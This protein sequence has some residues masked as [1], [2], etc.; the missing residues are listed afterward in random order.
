MI[1]EQ[2]LS[3]FKESIV[4][5]YSEGVT[6]ETNE[7]VKFVNYISIFNKGAS[8][9]KAYR[10]IKSYDMSE[11]AIKETY[12]YEKNKKVSLGNKLNITK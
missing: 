7:I 8:P 11:I 2:I 9:S 4:P 3:A 6:K 12:D 10:A 5:V 1:A